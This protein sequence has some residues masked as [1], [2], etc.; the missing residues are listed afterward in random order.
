MRWY[1][2][3]LIEAIFGTS[4]QTASCADDARDFRDLISKSALDPH[5]KC[6]RGGWAANASAVQADPNNPVF[7]DLDQFDVTTVTLHHG[8]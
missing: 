8:S 3:T 5:G 2:N 7:I 4:W 6:H 1:A